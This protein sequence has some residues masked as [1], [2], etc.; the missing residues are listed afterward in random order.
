M[1]I[2]EFR[3]K[4]TSRKKRQEEEKNQF[5]IQM[6]NKGMNLSQRMDMFWNESA[7]KFLLPF[8][9]KSAQIKLSMGKSSLVFWILIFFQSIAILEPHCQLQVSV[10]Y[11]LQDYRRGSLASSQHDSKTK[12]AEGHQ[13]E[14]EQSHGASYRLQAKSKNQ[15]W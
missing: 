7:D 11:Y 15:V 4:K 14:C 5:Q 3:N 12:E 1:S 8:L 9:E 10:F 2:S 6:V 13:A